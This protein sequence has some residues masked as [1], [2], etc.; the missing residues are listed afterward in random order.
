ME[1]FIEMN[2]MLEIIM[3]KVKNSYNLLPV[4]K[5]IIGKTKQQDT[6]QKVVD[7]NYEVTLKRFTTYV[8]ENKPTGDEN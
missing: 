6:L 5:Y 4:Q 7:M 1:T 3:E 2:N 8:L